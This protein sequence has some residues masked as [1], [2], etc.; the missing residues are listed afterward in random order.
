[1]S[2]YLK[3]FT[4][5][6]N[7]NP[8]LVARYEWSASHHGDKFIK[9]ELA[10]A[11]RLATTLLKTSKQFSHVPPE[12]ELAFKA[13][14]SATARLIAELSALAAW[15]RQ[16]GKFCDGERAKERAAAV[17]K[18]ATERWGADDGAVKFEVGI[19]NELQTRPGM[20]ALGRWLHSQG[21]GL[22]VSLD[23]F[24]LCVWGFKRLSL[25]QDKL[26]ERAAG[27]LLDGLNEGTP[28]YLWSDRPRKSYG[29]GW[30][31][32]QAYF[33]MRKSQIVGCAPLADV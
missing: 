12:H 27:M 21:R 4:A 28:S 30:R 14:A 23:N 24:S 11:R 7:A 26:R 29:V 17:E 16:Y 3:R 5:H 18:F 8:D 19:I 2:T 32:Y 10:A 33:E 9:V 1:M 22:D 6:S 13:A 25:E 31:E 15:A 20:E